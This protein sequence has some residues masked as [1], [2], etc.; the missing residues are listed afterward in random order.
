EA[1]RIPAVGNAYG[2]DEKASPFVAD[3]LTVGHASI[4][5]VAL[6]RLPPSS[7]PSWADYD[8]VLSAIAATDALVVDLRGNGGGD[9]SRGLQLARMLTDGDVGT[10]LVRTRERRTPEAL[11]LRLNRFEQDVQLPDGSLP[12]WAKVSYADDARERDE[13]ARHPM[14]DRIVD[15]A[16]PRALGPKAYAGRVAV[17]VDAACASS[18]ES[19]LQ[20]LRRFPRARVFGE[21]TAGYVNFGHLGT[22]VLAHTGIEIAIPTKYFELEGARLFD[23]VGF[24]PDVAVLSG[25]DAF[26]VATSW[27]LENLDTARILAVADYVVSE[28]V[29]TQENARLSK[30]GLTV[31]PEG[32][33]LAK[34]FAAP[35]SR[36]SFVVPGSWLVR[37][38]PRVVYA[39][40][41][42]ADLD[43]VEAVMARAYGGY[44]RAVKRGFDFKGW[45]ARW[46]ASLDGF[47]TRFVSTKDAFEPVRNLQSFQLDNHTTIPIDLRFGSGSRV[48]VLTTEPSGTCDA[49][50]DREGHES[51]LDT[52]DRAQV[53]RLGRRFDG[54]EVT[55]AWWLARPARWGDLTE[56][57][58]R[59]V[60]SA[61]RDIVPSTGEDWLTPVKE[62]AGQANDR[63]I[64]K[65]LTE[66]VA[67]VRLPTFSKANGEIIARE[68]TSW[69]RPTGKERAVIVDL[70]GNDGGDAA[71]GAL[72]GW[73]S[74]DDLASIVGVERRLGASC[75]YPPLRWGYTNVSS[76]SLEP[77]LTSGMR[78]MLDSALAE[79][80]KPDDPACPARF[81]LE[82]TRR[83]YAD[84]RP[85]PRKGK[86]L[87]M[88]LVDGGCGSDC[89]YMASALRK[90]PE[91][92][93]VGV[94]TFGVAEYIQPGY[95]ALPNTGLKYRIALGTSDIYG[96]GRS[97]DGY[98][99][100]VDVLL[101]GGRAWSKEAIMRLLGRLAAD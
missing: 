19:A 36:R 52:R 46:R 61:I 97:L 13:A 89:E 26:D 76:F 70:R 14:E 55:K 32:V 100:D 7:D 58:C 10:A 71:F 50:R 25:K 20:A 57:R 17:L 18:C 8:H 16:P 39:P 54:H 74:D 1:R 62:L 33:V 79:L 83:H 45:F 82:H 68:S 88:V 40:A 81:T 12:E 31:P 80:A 22:L 67:L 87:V 91:S 28:Q 84:R 53:P 44:D 98:G 4:G 5:V 92:V 21:R 77:P 11:T 43:A 94:N 85:P 73:L 56:I 64:A 99:L 34:P 15:A 69:E 65:H 96:D 41:L 60:W 51:P 30:L 3:I 2:A 63:P 86:P 49:V 24:D 78:S 9:D 23:K 42:R 6:H 37:R 38:T 66:A 35:Y 93:V 29:R 72:T 90:L 48:D 47:G 75:L 95:S 59:G 101:D 27:V